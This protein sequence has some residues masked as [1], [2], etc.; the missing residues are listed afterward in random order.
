MLSSQVLQEAIS[1]LDQRT[2]LDVATKYVLLA[3]FLMYFKSPLKS[4][5]WNTFPSRI[6]RREVSVQQGFVQGQER[7]SGPSL[8]RVVAIT[9][10]LGAKKLL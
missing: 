3:S 7:G 5:K 4:E 6:L 1:I 8:Q 9:R 2:D 10:R